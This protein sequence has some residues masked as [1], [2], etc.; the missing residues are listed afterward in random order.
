MAPD[1]KLF[2]LYG[3]DNPW[4]SSLW[5]DS[6]D[7]VRGGKSQS[8]L[9]CE[10]PETAKFFGNL[11]I[12][13]LGGAGFASQRTL[14]TLH[15]DLSQF[16]GLVLKVLQSD[17]KKYTLTIKDEILPP[18]EDGRD[19]STIS[20]EYDFVPGTGEVKISWDDFK[21]T[22]RGRPK[23]DAELLDVSNIKRIS[24]M[25]RSFF[26]TQEG[27]FS[28]T[29]AY[30]AA[31]SNRPTSSDSDVALQKDCTAALSH[32]SGQ[33]SRSSWLNWICGWVR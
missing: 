9:H 16:D 3:G 7:R 2:Y 25:M 17:S 22:Y 26:G 28:L 19:Q 8:H 12:T 14:G 27:D 10:S 11:D 15:L 31:F 30:L 13:A 6:D 21:P 24:F 5:T 4:D 1:W 20:W 18:R 29:V 32:A 33:Y 23:P